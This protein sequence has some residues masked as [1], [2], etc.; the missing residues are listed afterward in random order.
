LGHAIAAKTAGPKEWPFPTC[1]KL[2][3]QPWSS[4]PERV[5]HRF[6]TPPV[7][8]LVMGWQWVIVEKGNCAVIFIRIESFA[9]DSIE[10]CSFSNV[11]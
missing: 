1:E 8:D 2:N 10:I 4:Q 3:V 9:L 6:I 7:G 11:K 5:G